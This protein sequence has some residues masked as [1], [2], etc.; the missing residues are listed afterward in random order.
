MEFV[1]WDSSSQDMESH[2]PAMFQTTNHHQPVMINHPGDRAR[3]H[4][5]PVGQSHQAVNPHLP[6]DSRPIPVNPWIII[7]C[8]YETTVSED[9][10]S[11]WGKTFSLP[12]FIS[13]HFC[14]SVRADCNFSSFA[15]QHPST[16][17]KETKL[18]AKIDKHIYDWHLRTL[19]PRTTDSFTNIGS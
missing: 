9:A 19:V 1:K 7:S 10:V 13:V 3:R 15:C 14:A 6:G 11:Y 18:P 2:N 12:F 5:S 4:L 17:A 16:A 8:P